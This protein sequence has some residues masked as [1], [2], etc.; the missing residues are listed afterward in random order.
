MSPSQGTS[1]ETSSLSGDRSLGHLVGEAD[2]DDQMWET[3]DDGW[4][5]SC[6]MMIG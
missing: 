6:G 4:A 5:M 1:T 2:E 3:Q